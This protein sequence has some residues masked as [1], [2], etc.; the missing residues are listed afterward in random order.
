MSDAYNFFSMQEEIARKWEEYSVYKVKS[1]NNSD[2]VF[3]VDTPPPTVSGSL[4]IGHVFSYTQ[5]DIIARFKRITG[6]TVFY[7][8]GFDDNGLPTERYVEKKL[9]IV[10]HQMSR[11]D[12]ISTCLNEIKEVHESF[13][14]L[15]KKIG[16]SIDWSEC[17]STISPEVQKI[18]QK[19]FIELYK[20]GYVYRK[21]E[22]AL[23][24]PACRTS[25]S[26]AEL[27]DVE[28][29]TVF[30]TLE[31]SIKDSNEKILISTTRPEMLSGCV[32]IFYNP[33][34]ERYKN[35]ENKIAITPIYKKEVRIMPD[36]KVIKDKGTGIVMCCTFGDSLDVYWFKKYNLPYLKVIDLNGRMTDITDFLVGKTV[37]TGREEILKKLQEENYII[38]KKI[39]KHNVSIYE[40]S[41]KEIEYVM[42]KQWFIKILPFK[43]KLIELANEINWYPEH[44]KYRYINWVENLNWDWCISRQRFYGIPFPVWYDKNDKVVLPELEELPI[45][46]LKNE[47]N[48]YSELEPDTDVMDTW[49]TSSLTPFICMNLYEKS[50]GEKN[51]NFIPMS[52]RPQAHDIIRTWAFDTIVKA[53]MHNESIPWKD[54]VI[55][56]HVL[57]SESQKISK[58]KGNSP[59]DPLNLIKLYPADAIRYWTSSA[60]LGIDTAF[61]EDQLKNGSKLMVKLWNA[62]L[63]VQPH[64]DFENCDDILS[65]EVKED[66]NKWILNSLELMLNKFKISMEKYEFSIALETIEL[67][68]RKDF[69]DY[70]LEM[71]KVYMF[72]SEQFDLNVINE[73]K[74]T[75]GY[76]F[77]IILKTF[78]P[79]LIFITERIYQIL[80]LNKNNSFISIHNLI[81]ED[82]KLNLN[83]SINFDLIINLIDIIRKTKSDLKISLKTKIDFIYLNLSDDKKKIILKNENLLKGI[84]NIEN[85]IFDENVKEFKV[86]KILDDDIQKIKIYLN[87]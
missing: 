43:E 35:L 85:I 42:L 25:V 18:T 56:G 66:L 68:F 4:H 70:Y 27:E 46:P 67:F 45:D 64:G 32:A 14:E 59:L 1:L 61:S 51:N 80:Y 83:D 10:S 31:F 78:S 9:G 74:K 50:T 34:D 6:H 62:F 5:A 38:D 40:R 7:P 86:D 28:K 65:L 76:V 71:I 36:D 60:K 22:P 69:C 79:F 53:W 26:Q 39:I 19:S 2:K 49:N 55:S 82:I 73:T 3:T 72:K 57:S 29:E 30:V 8:F 16:L 17:Y 77:K 20:K 52:M 23:Y 12:F 48:K 81:L 24:C 15:W 63:C 47:N 84:C 75:I 44:M 41:K 58:S 13:V 87:L 54:I 33:T 21:N 11:S 37:F